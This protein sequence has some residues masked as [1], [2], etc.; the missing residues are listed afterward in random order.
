MI[1]L[2]GATGFLGSTILRKLA[3]AGYEIV[4]VKRSTSSCFRINDL[5]GLK[6]I[7]LFDINTQSPKDLFDIYA[8]DTII[9]TA[10]EYGRK[11]A[12]LC[13]I[14]NANLLLPLQLAELGSEYKV[15]SF[16]NT[17]SFFNK[18]S[19]SYSHLLNYSLSKK[20]LL[21]WLDNMKN[22][23][24]IVNV[25][26]EHIYGPHDGEAKFTEMIIRNVAINQVESLQL[27]HGHQ[28]RDF[29]YVDDVADAF[30]SIL[31]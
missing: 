15:N 17:D 31:Q 30:I 12:P 6:N 23:L 13:D 21:A 26:L 28:K 9:H 5:L 11:G 24:K 14:L 16:I 20:S 4:A 19:K 1:L 29:V 8:V 2:T 10:T 22:S 25:V 18:P 3:L 7:H 27:T